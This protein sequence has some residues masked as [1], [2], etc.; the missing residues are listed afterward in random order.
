LQDVIL[1]AIMTIYIINNYLHKKK[2]IYIKQHSFPTRRS[3]DLNAKNALMKHIPKDYEKFIVLV[4]VGNNGG[5]GVAMFRDL[6]LMKK[7]RSEEH[8]SEL[9][10]RFDL[11]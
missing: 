1:I 11:V 4:G 9:Q 5:D 2:H 10:S 8:T 3:S 6:L 7:D